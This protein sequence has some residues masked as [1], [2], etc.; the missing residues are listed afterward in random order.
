MPIPKASASAPASCS[1]RLRSEDSGAAT[2]A[3]STIPSTNSAGSRKRSELSTGRLL[4]A[5]GGRRGGLVPNPPHRDDRR[6]VAELPPQLPHVDVDGARVTRERVAP[7]PL[8]Q[9]I[10]RE[11]QALVVEELPEEVELLGRQPDLLVPEATL[12]PARVEYEVAVPEDTAV[13]LRLPRPAAEDGPHARHE[14]AWIEGFREVVVGADLEAGD[15]VEVV[16][17]GGQHQDGQRA[18]LAN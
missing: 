5:G 2:T 16:V 13:A 15:L 17:P 6:R 10:A 18:R 4:D 7:D 9:L 3:A 14:L 1:Q 8:E 12:A 11:D